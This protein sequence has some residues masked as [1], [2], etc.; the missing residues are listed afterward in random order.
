[1]GS[2]GSDGGDGGDGEIVTGDRIK[3][4]VDMELLTSLQ[5]NPV[6]AEKIGLVGRPGTTI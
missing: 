5:D 3:C 1:M 6:M 4:D 2:P